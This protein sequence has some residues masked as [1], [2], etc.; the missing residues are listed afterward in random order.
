MDNITV[1]APGTAD[2]YSEEILDCPTASFCSPLFPVWMTNRENSR[3][4]IQV[5]VVSQ[6]PLENRSSG[7]ASSIPKEKNH[8]LV[9][10]LEVFSS[11]VLQG[12]QKL[13]VQLEVVSSILLV[14][15]SLLY[16]WRQFHLLLGEQEIT[17][18][19]EVV[20]S[21]SRGTKAP[22]AAGDSFICFQGNRSSMSIWR[23]FHLLLVEQELTVQL[24]VVSSASRGTEA[25]CVAGG[26]FIDFQGEQKLTVELEVVSSTSK[27]DRS[28]LYSWRQFHLLLWR[29]EAQNTAE[30]CV[31]YFSINTSGPLRPLPLQEVMRRFS[32][33][34]VFLLY[35]SQ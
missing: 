35:P 24:E 33:L 20:L 6:S 30:G 28:S 13:T 17:V 2:N 8:E 34:S 1:Y 29:T 11:T 12:E 9:V 16:S 22:C 23:Q 26:S 3:L 21:A 19:L 7:V 14:Q 18:Q 31:V 25:H 5:K 10:Q 4:S 32:S 27:E 15:W